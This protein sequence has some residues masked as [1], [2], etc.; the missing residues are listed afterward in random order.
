MERDL[1]YSAGIDPS[2]MPEVA[3]V[4]QSVPSVLLHSNEFANFSFFLQ[5]SNLDLLPYLW[6][7]FLWLL[8]LLS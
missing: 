8:F 5:L 6:P 1:A 7:L 4:G 2:K 3:G